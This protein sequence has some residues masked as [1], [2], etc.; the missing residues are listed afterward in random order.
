MFFFA[1]EQ[2]LAMVKEE[3]K[4]SEDYERYLL[5]FG[6]GNK[7]ENG[8]VTTIESAKNLDTND[9]LESLNEQIEYYR[10][11]DIYGSYLNN[12]SKI[13]IDVYHRDEEDFVTMIG[14]DSVTEFKEKYQASKQ[15]QLNIER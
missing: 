7:D 11:N 9:I 5:V 4:H 6:F 13:V 1:S 15:S 12:E 2:E 8:E 14:W 3:F 10:K